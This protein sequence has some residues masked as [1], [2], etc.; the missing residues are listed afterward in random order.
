M[1]TPPKS[2]LVYINTASNLKQN[3]LDHAVEIARRYGSRLTL[4]DA[5][6]TAPWYM[7]DVPGAIGDLE[8][9]CV[10]AADEHLERF[11]ETAIAQGITPDIKV[12]RG[13]EWMELLRELE[14]GGYDLFIKT[15]M[16]GD[17]RGLGMIG[18]IGLRIMRKT[19]K[20]VL[21]VDP[22]DPPALDHVA[23][24]LNPDTG[25]EFSHKLL[26]Y[27]MAFAKDSGARLSA[28]HAWHTPGE[29]HFAARLP[30]DQY[31]TYLKSMRENAKAALDGFLAERDNDL[32][33]EQIHLVPGDPVDVVP[34]FVEKEQCDLLV[35]GTV[36][37]SGL[38]GVLMGNTAESILRR[39]DCSILALKPDGFVC[40]IRFDS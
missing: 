36:G 3:A 33:K 30:M 23:V 37:R 28:V 4:V 2:V 13:T 20:P 24:T 25:N 14:T 35:I 1:F 32:T 8:R 19:T 12:L 40:P 16:P 39:V 11:A 17:T 27:G 34:A 38:S 18:S 22:E 6:Q 26:D 5:V 29:S 15:R 9:V 21:I 7:V 10:K 31:E